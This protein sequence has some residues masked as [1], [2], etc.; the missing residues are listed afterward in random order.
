MYGTYNIFINDL[1]EISEENI[2]LIFL[3]MMQRFI[4]TLKILQTKITYKE[5]LKI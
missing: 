5:G 2:K 1:V 4:V 3:Q